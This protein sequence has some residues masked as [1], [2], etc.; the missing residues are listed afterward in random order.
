M[1]MGITTTN[2]IGLLPAT[3]A[4]MPRTTNEVWEETKT[5]LLW[6]RCYKHIIIVMQFHKLTS[7]KEK[8]YYENY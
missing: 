5:K 4:K 2:V 1:I 7:R 6:H 8:N 3:N